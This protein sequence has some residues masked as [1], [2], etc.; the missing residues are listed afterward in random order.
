MSDAFDLAPVTPGQEQEQQDHYRLTEFPRRA[1]HYRRELSAV[2]ADLDR[3][4]SLAHVILLVDR[5]R[6]V[7]LDI[8]GEVFA[9]GS[10]LLP[11]RAAGNR[12]ADFE[13]YAEIA[14]RHATQAL[15]QNSRQAI[16]DR[17]QM[18]VA[19]AAFVLDVL[20]EGYSERHA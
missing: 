6:R 5:V 14:H 18:A 3:S 11:R 8:Q 7:V 15:E 2:T 17:L 12:Q 13:T 20:I 16:I 4:P 9:L 1:D 19:I 10:E